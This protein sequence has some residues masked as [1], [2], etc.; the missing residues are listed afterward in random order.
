MTQLEFIASLIQSLA[1]PAV[2]IT[3]VLVI[4]PQLP[5][6]I[7]SLRRF[8][9]GDLEA[10]FGAGLQA[11]ESDLATLPPAKPDL[12]SP[13][14]DYPRI[15]KLAAVSPRSAVLEAW[16]S[17]EQSSLDLAHAQGLAAQVRPEP[18]AQ[19]VASLTDARLLSA[20]E[21]RIMS[22]LRRLR[23]AASHAATFDLSVAAAEEYVRTAATLAGA[24]HARTTGRA[25]GSS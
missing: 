14:F 7:Q 20:D 4:R 15:K 2:A 8:K 22:E 17:V 5:S 19:L 23:N 6:L 13:R 24:L 1:W 3:T 25:G 21:S 12:S 18:P 10:E 9:W 16:I 11:L